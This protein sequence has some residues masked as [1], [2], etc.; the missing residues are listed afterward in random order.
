M[1]QHV[2]P[3][4]SPQFEGSSLYTSVFVT[5]GVVGLLFDGAIE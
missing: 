2:E 4:S 3:P 1:C 5:I